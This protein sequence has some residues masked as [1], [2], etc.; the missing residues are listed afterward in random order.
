[1]KE[2][3]VKFPKPTTY[4]EAVN[5]QTWFY[6]FNAHP[7]DPNVLAAKLN[8]HF[9]VD[10]FIPGRPRVAGEMAVQVNWPKWR[11]ERKPMKMALQEGLT[12][13]Y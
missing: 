8:E 7:V 1:M 13:T 5:F 10:C 11:D 12:L 4:F 6:D 9:E 2:I 3:E